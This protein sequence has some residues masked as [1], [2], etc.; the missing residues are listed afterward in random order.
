L[1][2][3]KGGKVRNLKKDYKNNAKILKKDS[4]KT[5][6]C[7]NEENFHKQN[8]FVEKRENVIWVRR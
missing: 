6:I 3:V 7:Y 4:K 2:A 8:P 1:V 5:K